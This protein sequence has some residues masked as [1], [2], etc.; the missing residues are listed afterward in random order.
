MVLQFYNTL[1]RKKEVFK[2]IE[3]GKVR[4]YC[5]GPT[6]YNFA[7]IGN[8]RTYIFE[9][10]LRRVL[11]FND[12]EVEHVINITDVGHLT[13]DADD[14]EDKMEKGAKREG[15]SVLE[16]AQFYTDAFIT[17]FAK[18]NI[19]SPTVFPKASEHINEMIE[20]IK[21]LETNGYTYESEGN[22]LYD[23]SKFTY[24]CDLGRLNLAEMRSTERVSDDGSK[25]NKSDFVLWFTNSKFKN[26]S[27]MWDSP[28]GRGYPGWHIECTAMSSKYL[29]TQFDIHCGGVDHIQVHH[30]NEIAQA[31]GAFNCH[32]Y[33]KY[34]LH[35][36]FLVFNSGKMAKS[37]DTF[38]TLS[39]LEKKGYSPMEY[40]YFCSNTHY[41]KQ[42]NFSYDALDN[43]RSEF[44]ALFKKIISIKEKLG[45]HKQKS[46]MNDISLDESDL[47]LNYE[48]S[49]LESI[50]DDLNIPKSIGV[51]NKVISDSKLNDGEKLGLIYSFDKVLGFDIESWT[52][53]DL[54]VSNDELLKHNALLKKRDEARK[55]KDWETADKIRDELKS[56]GLS[57]KD[58]PNGATLEKIR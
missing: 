16:I 57:I 31:E 5:C 24:Y 13:D 25:K 33:V 43:A 2:S 48:K 28:W 38:I 1:T 3:E 26:H 27:L 37:G 58:G 6:V 8:L 54:S 45:L 30:T 53:D 7:H 51:L 46:T 18:L 21:L 9:D 23:T 55:N 49:F 11:E 36:E 10:F 34:W 50:N 12:Y 41:K 39:T 4:M 32:P 42:L 19:K 29:G 14:G 20:V 22:I 15:K 56:K 40:R 35:G 47:F 44:D 52:K 17:D